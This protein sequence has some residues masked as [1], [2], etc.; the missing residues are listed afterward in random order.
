MKPVIY[1]GDRKVLKKLSLTIIILTLL[2]TLVSNSFAERGNII[3]NPGFEATSNDEFNAWLKITSDKSEG[4]SVIKADENQRYTGNKSACI[5]NN[6]PNVAVL[7]QEVAVDP[8]SNYKLACYIK[9]EG[10]GQNGT[11]ANIQVLDVPKTSQDIK[12][13]NGKW[14]LVELYGRTGPKQNTITVALGIGGYSLVN[15]GKAWF[16]DVTVEKVTGF[17]EGVTGYNLFLQ[18]NGTYNENITAPQSNKLVDQSNGKNAYATPL[19]IYLIVFLVLFFLMYFVVARKKLKLSPNAEKITLVSILIVGL[20]FR[21]IIGLKVEGFPVD[22]GLFKWWADTSLKNLFGIYTS[23]VTIDYP[24]LYIFVLYICAK[25]NALN[26]GLNYALILK[27]PSIIAD[28]VTAYLIYRL[29]RKKFNNELGREFNLFIVFAYVFNPAVFINSTLWGQVDS[30]FTMFIVLAITLAAEDKLILS[31]AMFTFTILMK[32]QGII[33]LPVLFFQ[34]LKGKTLSKILKTIGISIVTALAITAV[35]TLPFTTMD[36]PFWIFKLVSKT[37]T[38]YPRASLNAFNLFALLGANLRFD[39]EKLFI[40]DYKTWGM[41]FDVMILAFTGFISLKGKIKNPSVVF[42]GAF[43][44]NAGA[45]VLS[46]EMHERYMFPSLALLL[47]T[48]LFLKDKRLI[49]VF[50]SIS[51][52]IFMNAH[53]VLYNGIT[54]GEGNIQDPWDIRLI[55]FSL[56]NVITFIYMVKVLVDNFIRNKNLPI[57]KVQSEKTPVNKPNLKSKSKVK[58]N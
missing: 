47:V 16:D 33:L 44:L 3:S 18:E 36:G 15:T 49:P 39:N 32:P 35:V 41:I 46:S 37:M 7:A 56:L 10:I 13:T 2:L 23:G 24:P 58:V 48:I 29:A 55:L 31:S 8:D 9:T 20:I 22:I 1:K 57:F 34:M 38:Q 42:A 53:I 14:Q 11:G 28:L 25:I 45:F 27:M 6:K 17:P 21:I 54:F 30:F 12:G 43:M 52:V 4:S 50:G 26:I 40:F 5:I 19:T 51:A